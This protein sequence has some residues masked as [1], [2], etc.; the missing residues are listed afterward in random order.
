[1]K[2]KPDDRSNNPHRIQSNISDTI[3]NIHLANE[4]IEVTDDEKTRETL[5]EKNHRREI[6][7]DALKK[8]LKD[9]TINQEVQEKMH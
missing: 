2:N 6:A 4:M 3:K 5:I 9:E 1:M 8:E 7:V